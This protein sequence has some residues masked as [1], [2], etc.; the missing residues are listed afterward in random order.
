MSI[1]APHFV[2]LLIVTLQVCWAQQRSGPVLVGQTFLASTIDPGCDCSAPWALTSHGISEKLFTVD[3]DGNIVGQVAQSVTKVSDFVW[4]VTLKS[5]YKF[6][7]GTSV[8]AELVAAGL[9]ELNTANSAAR[10][11]LGTM[12]VTAPSDLI[13]RIESTVATHVMDAVLAEWVFVVYYRDSGDNFVFTGPYAIQAGGFTDSQIDLIPNTYYDEAAAARPAI[14][15][16][17]FSSGQDLAEAAQNNEIDIGFH[18]PTNM[19]SEVRDVEGQNVVSFEVGYHYMMFH[20]TDNLDLNVRQAIDLAVDREALV[21]ALDGGVATRSL[22]PDYTPYFLPDAA[23]S[24]QDKFAEAATL[25][26]TA[27]WTLDSAT[28]KRMQLGE[29]LTVRL[30]AY[31]HRPDLV[32][33]QPIIEAALTGLGITVESVLTSMD[34]SETQAIIDGRSFDLLLWAQNTLPAGDPLWFLNHFF[35]SDGGN[36]LANLNSATVDALLDTLS[37]ADHTTRASASADAQTAILAE[38][39]VSNLITPYWHVSLS[40]RVAGYVPFGSDYHVLRADLRV[41][42]FGC[43]QK[44]AKFIVLDGDADLLALEQGVV[45]NLAEVGIDVTTELLERDAF[46]A[47]MTSGDFNL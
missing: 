7:D 24:L 25:L 13:V 41:A 37:S 30:I 27:G 35:R 20:N 3:A 10:A 26:D 12:T 19:L 42:P 1:Q 43:Q 36:N 40:D 17:K 5:G 44:S 6:S 46:N 15:L 4:E 18:L 28:G 39:P 31:P 9:T 16:K 33:M 47:A 29:E 23:G 8:S 2:V 34:W 11:S 32:T 21:T 14:T 45:A 22:F 38:V